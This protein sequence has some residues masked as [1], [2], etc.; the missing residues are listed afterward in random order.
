LADIVLW[1]PGFFAVKPEMV[2]KGGF[3]AWGA[4]G[5][6]SASVERGEPVTLGPMF[7]GTGAAPR[8]VSI[9]FVAGAALEDRA[10]LWHGRPEAVVKTRAI[11]KRHMVGNV[12]LPTVRVDPATLQVT[13][14]DEPITAEPAREV[15]LNRT[16]LLG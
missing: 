4:A 12:A 7:G 15:P 1:R 14:D 13:V 16:Y 3:I 6:G 5:P 2:V 9:R 11:R 8:D 10:R